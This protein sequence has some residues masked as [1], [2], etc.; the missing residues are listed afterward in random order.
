[1][2]SSRAR[3]RRRRRPVR[4]AFAFLTILLLA[5]VLLTTPQVHRHVMAWR[6]PLAYEETVRHYSAKH[7]LDPYL[8]M[9]LIRAE[10]GFDATAVSPVGATGLMQLMPSTAQWIAEQKGIPYDELDLFSAELNI[11]LGT[12][13]LRRLLDLFYYTDTALAAYNAGMGNVNNWL[14]DIRYSHDGATL[15]TIPF[16]E[17]R[18]YV[19]RV[20]RNRDMYQELYGR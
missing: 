9:G 16:G 3:S 7:D 4:L 15:H 10:S 18:E 1:M 8:V 5:G 12:Y 2:K 19:A 17:T 13:Y 14:G 20:N 6:F 11:R